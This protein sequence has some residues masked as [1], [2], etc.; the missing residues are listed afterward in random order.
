MINTIEIENNYLFEYILYHY[1]IKVKE[2]FHLYKKILKK[3]KT[4]KKGFYT[5]KIICLNFSCFFI[6]VS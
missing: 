6:N 3:N 5:L 4:C 2:I 1:T